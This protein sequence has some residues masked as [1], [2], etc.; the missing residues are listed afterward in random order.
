MHG[1]EQGPEIQ[2]VAMVSDRGIIP[3]LLSWHSLLLFAFLM[4]I[5]NQHLR[6]IRSDL[7]TS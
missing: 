6:A 1:L 3:V 7:H 5:L 2:E 4:P